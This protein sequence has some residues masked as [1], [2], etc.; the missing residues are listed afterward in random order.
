[1]C[2][3]VAW[4][5]D[6]TSPP[7]S[8]GTVR[9]TNVASGQEGIAKRTAQW[10]QR[11]FMLH[12]QGLSTDHWNSHERW[13]VQP[14]KHGPCLNPGSF[15]DLLCGVVLPRRSDGVALQA[16][17]SE[18]FPTQAGVGMSQPQGREEIRCPSGSPVNPKSRIT[19]KTCFSAPWVTAGSVFSCASGHPPNLN[20]KLIPPSWCP[21]FFFLL[22]LR[23]NE[24]S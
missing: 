10:L 8:L 17:S 21:F 19:P 11:H 15:P 9:K 20:S 6:V 12:R 14:R 16:P 13:W 18:F 22:C 4:W 7:T 2:A 5:G 23:N 1:M 24:M 3:C